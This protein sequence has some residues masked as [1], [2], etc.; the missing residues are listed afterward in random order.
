MECART[1]ELEGGDGS[2]GTARTLLVRGGLSRVAGAFH[3]HRLERP[4]RPQRHGLQLAREPPRLRAA[5][6]GGFGAG[7]AGALPLRRP[8]PPAGD[9]RPLHERLAV[10]RL[11][12]DRNAATGPVARDLPAASRDGGVRRARAPVP[13]AVRAR[14]GRTGL[15]AHLDRWRRR[16]ALPRLRGRAEG[17]GRR[18]AAR[19]LPRDLERRALRLSLL[20]PGPGAT[21]PW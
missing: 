3:L 20:A 14:P 21:A 2:A 13:A 10:R 8:A 16:P 9:Q 15:L 12:A 19:Q 5:G 4:R 6:L 7:G 11:E 1:A 17:R 18:H